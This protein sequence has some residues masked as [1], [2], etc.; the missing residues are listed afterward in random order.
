MPSRSAWAFPA[1][2]HPTNGREEA[3]GRDVAH[4][5]GGVDAGVVVVEQYRDEVRPPL[6]KRRQFAGKPFLHR[7]LCAA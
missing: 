1:H 5:K 4:A 7:P 6:R 2:T 3:A